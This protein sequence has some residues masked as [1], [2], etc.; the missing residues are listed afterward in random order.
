MLAAR[1][2]HERHKN[3]KNLD[4]EETFEDFATFLDGD[5]KQ[6]VS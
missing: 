2:C 3:T 4:S 5:W 6:E 1:G